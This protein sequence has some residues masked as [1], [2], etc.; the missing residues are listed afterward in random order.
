MSAI[1]D[2]LYLY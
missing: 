1:S 2:H